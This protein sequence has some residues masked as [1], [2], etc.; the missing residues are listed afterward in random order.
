MLKQVQKKRQNTQEMP[1]YNNRSMVNVLFHL[2]RKGD[3]YFNNILM[4]VF[5]VPHPNH[6]CLY[7]W[8]VEALYKKYLSQASNYTYSSY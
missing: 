4:M 1:F 8:E 5:L 7:I 3:Y 2:D 6:G